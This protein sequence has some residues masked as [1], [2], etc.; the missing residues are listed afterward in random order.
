MPCSYRMALPDV[1][2]MVCLGDSVELSICLYIENVFLYRK[3]ED[4]IHFL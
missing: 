4:V 2:N 1:L 3:P